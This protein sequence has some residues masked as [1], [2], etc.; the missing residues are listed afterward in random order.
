MKTF[1][2]GGLNPL[3]R[4]KTLE[5]A[6]KE[7][8]DDDTIE[9]HKNL[10]FS[11]VIQKNIILEGNGH[12]MTVE[13][14][15]VGL[16]CEAP[17]VIRNLTFA[18]DPRTNGAIL[19][20]GGRLQKVTTTIKG[21]ARVLL[22]TIIC[23]A[24]KLLINDCDLM[25]LS[26]EADSNVKVEDSTFTDYYGG[27]FHLP[28]H[29]NLSVFQGKTTM[30][31]CYI[32]C[33]YFWGTTNIIQSTLE[34]FNTNS[35]DLTLINCSL[36]P[37]VQEPAV[38]LKKEPAD[39]PL[40]HKN[41]NSKFVL[42]Q[43]EGT[44]KVNNYTSKIPEVFVGFHILK[45]SLDIQNTENADEKGYHIIRNASVSFTDTKD[46]AYY[47]INGGTIS[48]VRS[49]VNTS[50][51][52]ETAMEKLNKLIGL[53]SVKETL[54]SILNTIK[55]NQQSR[56][57]DKNFD[58][59]YSMVFAGDPGTGKT[60]V[61]K[62]VAQALFE[63]GAIPENKCTQVSVDSLVKGY[64]GQTAE[65]V[66][67]VLD[68][69]LGGVLFIDEAYELTV[70]ENQNSFNSEVLSVLIRYME[71]YRDQLVVIAAG[72]E[73]EMKEFLASNI[74]L[75]RRF[76]WIPFED[77]TPDEMSQIFELMRTSYNEEYEKENLKTLIPQ[78]FEKLTGLYLRKPDSKG[79]ITNGG[80]GGLVR[81]AF[82]QVLQARNNRIA[83]HPE[84]GRKLT[85]ADLM[86]GFRKEMEKA[87]QI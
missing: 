44:C 48:Q 80:N 87:I 28:G 12:T 17:I 34:V 9:L 75:S 21:P 19:K 59:S 39:G 42:E 86:A 3:R 7:A 67:H 60:T 11:G 49:Q 24:G 16:V 6:L 41:E 45:G 46:D 54:Q 57:T 5:A 18:C 73:K 74:G 32:S 72:Y 76:Q 51:K 2:I 53:K 43:R 35:G 65:H 38:N 15:K 83:E 10:T 14:G 85:Q 82:Q 26:C 55:A 37:S 64:V 84:E 52:S 23:K 79:R 81:N 58:F 22:P 68:D 62:I 78:F 25:K 40:E 4:Y 33:C 61:A 56:G 29:E 31:N 36:E 13:S 50:I 71:D 63:V 27:V 66:R 70:K 1:H 8:K 77:Y 69:A 47:E 20:K 30:T